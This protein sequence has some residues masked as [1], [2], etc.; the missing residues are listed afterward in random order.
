MQTIL[1]YLIGAVKSRTI[2][3]N[4]IFAALLALEPVF[5]MLQNFL[6]GNV[7]AWLSVML[8][9]GNAILRAITSQHLLEK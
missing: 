5:G 1:E 2:W 6:P 4:L 3:F 9:V 8:T 7:Y